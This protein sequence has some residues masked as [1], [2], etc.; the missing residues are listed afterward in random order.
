MK[1][2]GIDPGLFGGIGFIAVDQG[3]LL[4]YSSLKMPTNK[5]RHTVKGV[6][7]N[8]VDVSAIHEAVAYERPDVII[9]ERQVGRPNQSS[10][11]THTAGTNY[12]IILSL[13]LLKLPVH[14]V[15]PDQWKKRL[16]ISKD[17]K[18]ATDLCL[19][20]FGASAPKKDGPA[21]ALLLAWYGHLEEL[22]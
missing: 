9:I 20:I 5:L 22:R 17:K 4:N 15:A 1:I 13:N 14:I 11:A 10:V 7:F 8:M 21:E 12:G 19:S 18:E 6:T 16:G 2:C 3:E